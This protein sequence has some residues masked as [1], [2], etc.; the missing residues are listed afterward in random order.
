MKNSEDKLKAARL[1]REKAEERL[2]EKALGMTLNITEVRAVKLI[3]ELQ[4]HQIE[5]EMQNEELLSAMEQKEMATEK[6]IELFDFLPS[7]YFNLTKEGN[8][9]AVNLSGSQL[10]G[11]QRI[12]LINSRLGFFISDETKPVFNIFLNKIFKDRVKESCEV[13][14]N[15]KDTRPTY[16]LLTGIISEDPKECHIIMVDFTER[17][18]IEM[19][20][21]KAKEQ[22]MAASKAK[23]DFL[24]NMSHEIRTPLNGIIGFTGL[25]MGSNLDKSQEEY[26]STINESANTLIHI[27]NEVLDFSKIEAGKLELEISETDLFELSNQV[28]DL[29][30]YQTLEKKIDLI[31]N[32]DPQIPQFVQADVTRLKQVLVNL[33]SNAVKFTYSGTITLDVTETPTSNKY[34]STINFSVRDTGIGIEE[35]NNEKIFKSFMQCDSSTCR[36]FGG[37][38]LGLTIS[39]QLLD[40]M[41]SKL[42]VESKF[43]EGSNFFFTVQ[44]KKS[45]Q[46]ATKASENGSSG[47]NDSW[48]T[49]SPLNYNKI[50]VVEDN[51]IN[52]FLAKTLLKRI[53]PNCDIIEAVDGNDGIEKYTKEQPDIVLMD[54]QMPNKNGYDAASDI[55][56][57]K[58]A[59]KIPII[60]MTAGIL[61]GEKEK[62]F[63]V[64][65][66]DYMPKPIIIAD[67]VR[68]LHKWNKKQV[69]TKHLL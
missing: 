20:L 7:A 2:K 17:K 43:G 25:L 59:E 14:L 58:G 55:R 56:K 45:N 13:V 31:L 11:K 29:F 60:A 37:T 69:E 67:L 6:Y 65:M 4:V 52:M 51:K 12:K 15:V 23:T 27:V 41:G 22:A 46:S 40:L 10:L 39:N 68:I 66:D 8:V 53:I 64:G 28:I 44:F 62:C 3:H 33:I 54:I 38:G 19:E 42:N 50:L 9:I 18:L 36:Q 61:T 34:Y 21:I 30:K 48:S 57:L 47:N 5:L 49:L 35:A 63:E 24:A 1:L 26:M 32:I 16:V